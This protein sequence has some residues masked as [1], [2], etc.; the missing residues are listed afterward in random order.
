MNQNRLSFF[1]RIFK[2]RTAFEPDP[3]GYIHEPFIRTTSY[4]P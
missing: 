2:D 1:I 4:L 3:S